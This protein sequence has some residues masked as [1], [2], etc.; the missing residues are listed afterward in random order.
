MQSE[1]ALYIV[2]SWPSLWDAVQWNKV[3]IKEQNKKHQ[4]QKTAGRGYSKELESVLVFHSCRSKKKENVKFG[5]FPKKPEFN[6]A[7]IQVVRWKLVQSG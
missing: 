3:A 4:Q 1:T 7:V 5:F 2:L 6:Q